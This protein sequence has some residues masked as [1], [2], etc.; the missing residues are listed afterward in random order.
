MAYEWRGTH[1]YYYEK[2]WENGTCR[3]EYMRPKSSPIT[4]CAASLDRITR[5]RRELARMD[6]EDERA[7][8]AALA[9][10][11]PSLLELEAAARAAVARALQAA[12]Y[13]QH[14]RGAGRKKRVK[15]DENDRAAGSAGATNGPAD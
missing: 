7:R 15:K 8:W 3:S 4:R 13:H 12:G 10:P 9:S 11:P 1:L 2:R 5:D 14:D 6:A